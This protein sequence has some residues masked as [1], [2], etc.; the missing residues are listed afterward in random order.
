VFDDHGHPIH[1]RGVVAAEPGL[2]FLGIEFQF[3]ATS[4][5]ITG[6]GRDARYIAKHIT[7]HRTQ[8]ETHHDSHEHNGN[9]GS[10]DRGSLERAVS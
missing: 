10:R 7:R 1:S 5:V 4:D 3:A 9:A 2:Y 6:V 8:G